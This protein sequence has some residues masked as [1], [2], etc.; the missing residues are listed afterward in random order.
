MN[1]QQT[2]NVMSYFWKSLDCELCMTEYPQTI[3]HKGTKFDL[4]EIQKPECPYVVLE[5]VMRDRN[6][7]IGLYII[8]MNNK[9]NIRLGR[10]HDSDIRI[11]DISVSR[12]HALIQFE[13]NAFY[14]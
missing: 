12:F 1:P 3:N 13:D 6:S 11:S 7:R 4:M 9:N 2:S 14:L 10:G 8:S 5:S